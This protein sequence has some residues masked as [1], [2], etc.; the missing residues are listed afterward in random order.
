MLPLTRIEPLFLVNA[1]HSLVTVPTELP[2]IF[3]YIINMII[4]L[5]QILVWVRDINFQ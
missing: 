1:S 2:W 5:E 3:K 4:R